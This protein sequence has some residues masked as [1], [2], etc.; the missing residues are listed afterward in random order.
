[1]QPWDP[2][3]W[4][5]NI[6]RGHYL[7]KETRDGATEWVL[8]DV[9]GPGTIVR[10]WSANPTGTLFFYVD[11]ARRPTWQAGFEELCSGKVEPFVEPMAGIRGRGYNFHAPIPFQESIVVTCSKDDHHYQVGVQLFPEGTVVNSF[12]PYLLETHAEVI[13][14][15]RKWMLS[16]EPRG[17]INDIRSLDTVLTM[18]SDPADPDVWGKQSMEL[19]G[20]LVIKELRLELDLPEDTGL[21]RANLL[22]RILL[23]IDHEGRRTVRV[24]VSDF[25]GS[26]PGFAPYRGLPLAVNEDDIGICRFPI[27][28]KET[29]T[30]SLIADGP[31]P[32]VPFLLFAAVEKR[33]L[34]DDALTFHA[35][36]HIQKGIRTR[37][38]RDFRV[39]NARGPGR[40][41]G[42]TFMIANPSRYWWGEGDEKFFVDGE[43]FP[44]TFGTGTEDYFGYAWADPNPFTSPYHAQPQCD[45]PENFGYTCLNRFQ[46]HD[47]VPFQ[48]SFLF[49]LEI[50]HWRDVF[51]D[52]ATT[53]Y[54][55]GRP[56]APSGLPWV[57]G[58]EYR[59]VDDIIPEPIVSVPGARE[60]ESLKV[61]SKTA[62][63]TETPLMGWYSDR[64]WSGGKHLFW[65]DAAVGDV[66][67]LELP[68]EDSGEYEIEAVFTVANDYATVQASLIGVKLGEPIDL[69][70]PYVVE[71]GSRRSLH[72]MELP[73]G[74]LRFELEI[75]GANERAVKRYGVGLDY[76]RLTRR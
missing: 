45:G 75:V 53:A 67:T 12:A 19:Q 52:Y 46:I 57:P 16:D 23:C 72:R 7:R 28:I 60:G 32:P 10:I 13:A 6:D 36:W 55:Y 40:F 61:L 63:E 31:L 42:C 50:W 76:L 54:W 35:S 38:I 73:A 51:V 18:A 22:R 34:P 5:S 11:G 56:D 65:K 15:T 66:L 71:P 27:P 69:F 29:A 37:P 14:I 17:P 43:P 2:K 20:P 59:T 62:G 9:K 8:A 70:T 21:D 24:P 41:V 3:G 48:E 49:D 1:M 58:W 68:V 30:V 4:Y 33:E 25:F 74:D 26:T 44:S 64:R 47:S 39:L